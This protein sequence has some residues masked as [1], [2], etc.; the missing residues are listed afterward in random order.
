MSNSSNLKKFAKYASL[1]V[2][3]MAFLSCYIIAD[4]YFISKGLGEKGLAALNLAIPVYSAIH[5]C[6]LMIGMGGGAKYSIHRE[7]EEK[8]T[9]N[10]LFT[11]SLYAA[12]AASVLFL[13]AGIFFSNQITALLGADDEVFHMTNVYLKVILIFAPAFIMNNVFTCFVRN[14]GAPTFAA[15]AMSVGSVANIILD[16]IFVFP[17]NMGIFGAVLATGFSPVISMSILSYRQIKKL[18]GFRA[19]KT[20]VDFKNIFSIIT[21]GF[22][23]L[24]TELSSGIVI[25]VFNF[26]ILNLEGNVGV[27]AYGVVANISIVVIAAYTGI[28]QGMQ[29]LVS[30]AYGKR[31]KASIKQIV[32]YAI[33]TLGALSGVI[34]SIVFSGA[35]FIAGIFGG[36]NNEYLQSV[37]VTGLKLYFI[38]VAFVGLN[39]VISMYFTSIEKPALAQIISVSRGLFVIVPMT[40]LL[41]RIAGITGVWLSFPA[42]EGAVAV[43]SL[44]FFI[45]SEKNLGNRGGSI[46]KV[47][48]ARSPEHGAS[49]W[50]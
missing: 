24:I 5:G 45:K 22:P 2:L 27:A 35:D 31:D 39:I 11:N 43:L 32:K 25:I 34:Y 7:R 18:S 29:P 20:A 13:L 26:I 8:T 41:S 48:L 10:A 30:A 36:D 37:A 4:T 47:K 16:Y 1:N 44:I 42:S 6:G 38:A 40:F 17:M 12:G 21:L 49:Y 3:G 46:G 9:T 50:N 15:V 14:D 33:V 28:A 23:S 19:I